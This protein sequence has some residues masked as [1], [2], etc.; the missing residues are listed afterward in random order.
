MRENTARS[1]RER[2]REG[3]GAVE[4]TLSERNRGGV[5]GPTHVMTWQLSSFPPPMLRAA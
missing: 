1:P 3:W 2:E 4:S 5:V